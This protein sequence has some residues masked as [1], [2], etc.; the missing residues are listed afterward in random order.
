MNIIFRLDASKNNGIGHL[1]RCK[2]LASSLIN[3]GA[4]AH[5]IMRYFD[6][7]FRKFLKIRKCKVTILPKKKIFSKLDHEN[8]WLKDYKKLTQ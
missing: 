7:E 2:S 5:F 8:L 3:R 6:M 4:K 1:I